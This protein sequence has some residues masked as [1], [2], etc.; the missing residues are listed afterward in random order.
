MK[1]KRKQEKRT[2]GEIREKENRKAPHKRREHESEKIR[3][4]A[5]NQSARQTNPKFRLETNNSAFEH[6]LSEPIKNITHRSLNTKT[7]PRGAVEWQPYGSPSPGG[8]SGG[9]SPP[10]SV[11]LGHTSSNYPQSSSDTPQIPLRNIDFR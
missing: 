10:A 5:A 3:C 7:T 1:E 9:R 4:S 11:K 6:T 8:G 2:M